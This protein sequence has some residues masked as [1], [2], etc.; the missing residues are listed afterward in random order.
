LH[1]NEY[2]SGPPGA[3]MTAQSGHVYGWLYRVFRYALDLCVITPAIAQ[4]PSVHL[5]ETDCTY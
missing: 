5:Q 2:E 4:K 1:Y 3:P